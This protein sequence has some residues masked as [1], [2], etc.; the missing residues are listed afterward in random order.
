[1]EN[2]TPM[3][4]TEENDPNEYYEIGYTSGKKIKGISQNVYHSN[5]CP[6]PAK[7][8]FM[9]FRIVSEQQET[10]VLEF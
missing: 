5:R 2:H 8:N 10:K 4:H 3:K 7:K 1:M 6:L 9:P